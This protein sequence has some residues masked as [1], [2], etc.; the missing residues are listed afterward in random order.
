MINYDDLDRHLIPE[1]N[2]M[3]PFVYKWNSYV[4]ENELRALI[5]HIPVVPGSAEGELVAHSMSLL[6]RAARSRLISKL[7]SKR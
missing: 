3:W 7:L 5:Q 4:F 2:M 1:N 6:L